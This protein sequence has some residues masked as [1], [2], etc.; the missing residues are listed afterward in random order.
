MNRITT[1]PKYDAG[2]VTIEGEITVPGQYRTDYFWNGW[3]MVG[4]DPWATVRVLDWI[5][6]ADPAVTWEWDGDVL[7]Y[8][9]ANHDEE[10]VEERYEPDAD[11]LYALGSGGWVWSRGGDAC[12]FCG[13]GDNEEAGAVVDGFHEDSNCRVHGEE[14]RGAITTLL[15]PDPWRQDDAAPSRSYA[16]GLPVIITV[17]DDGFVTAEVDT[18]EAPREIRRYDLIPGDDTPTPE[19][20]RWDSQVVERWAGQYKVTGEGH[21]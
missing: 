15:R 1:D 17:R 13:E 3:L 14:D 5:T 12:R 7:V 8:R 11:G 2:L 21:A 18:S 10:D 16:V 9:D 20:L 6:S 4:L 19:D